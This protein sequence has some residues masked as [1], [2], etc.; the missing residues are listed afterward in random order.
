MH[1]KVFNTF[2]CHDNACNKQGKYY[3]KEALLGLVVGLYI[4]RGLSVILLS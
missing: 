1:T 4:L 3:Q 2:T